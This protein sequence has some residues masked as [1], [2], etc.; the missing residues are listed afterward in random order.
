M[1]LTTHFSETLKPFNKWISDLLIF[2]DEFNFL[3]SCCPSENKIVLYKNI[4][5]EEE[6]EELEHEKV[7]SLIVKWS[8][9]KWR[10]V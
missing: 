10:A 9:C 8:I 3:I 2:N 1:G 7:L 5:N 6:R 4:E